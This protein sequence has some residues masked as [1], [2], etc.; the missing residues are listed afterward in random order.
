MR[1]N[2]RTGLLMSVLIDSVLMK[3][4]RISS[5]GIVHPKAQ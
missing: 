1:L 4:I 5:V 2:E 3:N